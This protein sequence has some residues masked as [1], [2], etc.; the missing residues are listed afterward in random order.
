M[1]LVCVLFPLRYWRG[2]GQPDHAWET[3]A[4]MTDLLRSALLPALTT[5]WCSA[6]LDSVRFRVVSAAVVIMFSQPS[7]IFFLIVIDE[8]THHCIIVVTLN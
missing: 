8:M 6:N 4:L 5:S 2:Y 7:G 3:F 1:K